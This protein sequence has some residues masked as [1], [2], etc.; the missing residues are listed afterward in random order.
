M[1]SPESLDESDAGELLA[2]LKRSGQKLPSQL[3]RAILN[4]GEVAVPGLLAVLEDEELAA[5]DSAAGGWPPIHAM[6]LLVALRAESA[7][8]PMLTALREGD[9]DDILST[10]IAVCLP[11]FGAIALEPLLSEHSQTTDVERRITL[12]EMLS[13]LPVRDPRVWQALSNDFATSPLLFSGFLANYGDPRGVQLIESALYGFDDEAPGGWAVHDLNELVSAY[14]R[15]AGSLPDELGEHVEYLL[16]TLGV[17][18]EVPAVS[19]KVGRNDP[20]P[21]GSGKKHKR[22]CLQ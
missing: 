6:E 20:C 21:C 5:A 18:E 13:N 9:L 4:L 8:A 12:C 15:L 14:E 17:P 7:I 10:R 22:C 2:R 1:R 3:R 11:E 16:D 19:T